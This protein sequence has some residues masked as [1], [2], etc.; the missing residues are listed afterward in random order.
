MITRQRIQ[1]VMPKANKQSG[2]LAIGVLSILLAVPTLIYMWLVKKESNKK[3]A[4]Y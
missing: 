3:E 4:Y 1:D 2:I